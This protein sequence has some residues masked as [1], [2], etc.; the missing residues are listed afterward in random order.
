M[1]RFVQYLCLGALATATLSA[2]ASTTD[3]FTIT[4]NGDTYSFMLP[5]S[6]TDITSYNPGYLFDQMN[7]PVVADGSATVD[8]ITFYTAQDGGGTTLYDA[9]GNGVVLDTFQIG[10]AEAQ[11]FSGDVTSPT[12]LLGTFQLTDEMGDPTYSITISTAE[13]PEPSSLLLLGTGVAGVA[14]VLRRRLLGA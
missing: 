4:G 10:T 8:N 13:T 7:V 9:G 12:F 11:L 14:G 6:P 3:Q 2:H 5:A 1:I